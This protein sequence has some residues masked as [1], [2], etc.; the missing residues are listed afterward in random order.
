MVQVASCSVIV[1]WISRSN[2]S[3]VCPG[4][5]VHLDSTR[6][7]SIPFNCRHWRDFMNHSI[8]PSKCAVAW[9]WSWILPRQ[10][11]ESKWTCAFVFDRLIALSCSKI[12]LNHG[13]VD[14]QL[15]GATAVFVVRQNP[16]QCDCARIVC[17]VCM[18]FL[19]VIPR[20]W[21]VKCN[22]LS[23]QT[24]WAKLCCS[25]PL[26]RTERPPPPFLV[27]RG[28]CRG[29]WWAS[30]EFWCESKRREL[31]WNTETVC[32]FLWVGTH[33]QD[34]AFKFEPEKEQHSDVDD[35]TRH[36][37]R[38]CWLRA[39]HGREWAAIPKCYIKIS[40]LSDPGSNSLTCQTMFWPFRN[41]YSWLNANAC[42]RC[43]AAFVVADRKIHQ[44]IALTPSISSP[45]KT[46][47]FLSCTWKHFL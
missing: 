26:C 2:S 12:V 38:R 11:T 9:R 17:V 28:G 43:D 47:Q 8:F 23:G 20:Q 16:C 3:K 46:S 5:I 13:I 18:P 40:H 45:W 31:C 36:G 30:E 7:P 1:F 44:I 34:G 6:S 27:H 25:T 39:A 32:N 37:I 33:K 35:E 24:V 21:M 4:K 19:L 10:R 42:P 14:M 29:W 41:P 15:W 22:V